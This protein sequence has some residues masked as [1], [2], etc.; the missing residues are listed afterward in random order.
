MDSLVTGGGVDLLWSLP[1]VFSLTVLSFSLLDNPSPTVTSLLVPRFVYL[2]LCIWSGRPWRP[3]TL[4]WRST[5]PLLPTHSTHSFWPSR[6]WTIQSHSLKIYHP[7]PPTDR[8]SSRTFFIF[9][10]R[11]DF[12][13]SGVSIVSSVKSFSLP[14]FSS[15]NLFI[16]FNISQIFVEVVLFLPPVPVSSLLH[17]P[18]SPGH[19]MSGGSTPH[20]C[21]DRTVEFHPGPSRDKGQDTG[22][23]FAAAVRN[24]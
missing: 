22:L 3:T 9:R 18:L 19:F 7:Q 11:C 1:R 12:I 2:L 17:F 16:H 23:H 15:Y 5:E 13:L 14:L 24:Y 4:F 10:R 20:S 8:K 21:H 6:N